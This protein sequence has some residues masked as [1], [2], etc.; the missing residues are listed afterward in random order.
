MATVG[1]LK[2][3]ITACGLKELDHLLIVLAAN[4][5][6]LPTIV[7]KAMEALADSFPADEPSIDLVV[8]GAEG[9]SGEVL[10]GEF[11]VQHG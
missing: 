2:I 9:F 10:S 7:V 6:N 4:I 8:T 11:G 5:D 3:N 1:E